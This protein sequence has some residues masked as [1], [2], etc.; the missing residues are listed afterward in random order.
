MNRMT[1]EMDDWV[2]RTRSHSVGSTHSVTDEADRD[3]VEHEIFYRC[4]LREE[5][6]KANL[7]R[8]MYELESQGIWRTDP[9]LALSME[10]TNRQTDR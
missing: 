1:S 7:G 8:M 2:K 4:K 3:R 10:V 6:A 9:R 5:D